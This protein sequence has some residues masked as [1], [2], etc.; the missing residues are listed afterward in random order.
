MSKLVIIFLANVL[1]ATFCFSQPINPGVPV[2][3]PAQ[4]LKNQNSFLT[5]F[6]PNLNLLSANYTSYN[7][8][9]KVISKQMFLWELTTGKYL[10][11]RLSATDGKLYYRLYKLKPANYQIGQMLSAYT[12][13]IYTNSLKVGTKFPSF[14]FV[15][16]NGKV[17]N[18]ENTKGKVIVLKCWFI[19][20]TV[21]NQEMPAPNQLV[22]QYK[23]NKDIIF[24]SLASDTKPQLQDFLKRREFDY[25]VVPN[26]QNFMANTLKVSEYPT[27]FIINKQGTVVSVV[28]TPEE[29][30][31]ALKNDL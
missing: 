24:I 27:H 18:T 20:C 28:D 6:A 13:S 5:Y 17:Y 25:V 10:P 21:C 19:H 16:V 29:I 15:D 30:E 22:K 3:D 1:C 26:Q 9:S 31:Y 8:K 14:N 23:N 12:T 4:I 7:T 2:E 11:L